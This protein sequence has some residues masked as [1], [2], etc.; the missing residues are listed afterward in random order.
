MVKLE[1]EGCVYGAQVCMHEQEQEM[2]ENRA[3]NQGTWIW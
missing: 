2:I 1:M 3:I